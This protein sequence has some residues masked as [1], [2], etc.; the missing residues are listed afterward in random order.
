[1]S[2]G[3]WRV[4]A[5]SLRLFSTVQPQHVGQEN[6]ERDGGRLVLAGQRE[7]G[8]AAIGDDAL[9]PLSRAKPRRDAR[10][11]RVIVDD[12]QR[13][14]ALRDLLTVVGDELLAD[15][16]QGHRRGGDRRLDGGVHI[17]ERQIEGEGAALAQ[18]CC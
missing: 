15:D 9:K 16:R 6:I 1:M 12:E 14:V 7:G 18:P 5:P 11:I 8:V 17:E 3:M 13:L 4:L 10:V 2:T